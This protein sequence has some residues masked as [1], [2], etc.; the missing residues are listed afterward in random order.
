MPGQ[1]D[2]VAEFIFWG[3]RQINYEQ[4]EG[5][6]GE[7]HFVSLGTNRIHYVTA[8][9]GKRTIVFIH[10]WACH[11]GVWRE[12]ISALADKARLILIDL[13]GHGKSDKPK[14]AYSMDFFG[15]AVLAV[16][17]E[18]A[19]D[20]AIFIGHSLGVAVICRVCGQ[21]PEKVAAV[22]SV[23]GHLRQPY[24]TA[25]QVAELLTPFGS[26]QYLDHARNIILTFFPN[27]GTEALRDRVMAE[28]LA[29]PQHVMQSALRALFEPNH[30]DWNL[31]KVN[32]PV[33]VINVPS[34]RWTKG[35]KRY[36]E[37][38]SPRSEFVVMPDAGHFPMLEKPAEFN[39]TLSAMLGRAGLGP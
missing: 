38:R 24:G 11:L 25:E 29:T 33:L 10:G 4:S 31:K 15:E 22:V 16:V 2:R 18:A 19:V 23:D 30:V 17:R 8:G 35:L 6:P 20:Q 7:T 3:M 5:V 27:P 26:P 13:P 36:V 1:S 39:A 37:D 14:T 12:Q 9:R 34:F 32:V 28:M 21:A